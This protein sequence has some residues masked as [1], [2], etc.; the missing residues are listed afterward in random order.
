[1]LPARCRRRMDEG[2]SPHLPNVENIMMD[3]KSFEITKKEAER[4][5][6]ALELAATWDKTQ[7]Y[8]KLKD[9]LDETD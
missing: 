8:Y 5:L 3:K 9:W 1:M 6:D 7:I 4:I 2:V